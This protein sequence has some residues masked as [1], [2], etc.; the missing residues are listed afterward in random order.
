M[1]R[2]DKPPHYPFPEDGDLNYDGTIA[3]SDFIHREGPTGPVAPDPFVNVI[4]ELFTMFDDHDHSSQETSL[5]NIEDS[6]KDLEDIYQMLH[7]IKVPTPFSVTVDQVKD[8]GFKIPGATGD[9]AIV[10][11]RADAPSYIYYDNP[12]KHWVIV[13]MAQVKAKEGVNI[14]TIPKKTY[15]LTVFTFKRWP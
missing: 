13:E 7:H 15:H 10:A 11:V 4:R 9:N 5:N 14:T 3:N 6:I 8:V 2:T 12:S 1:K